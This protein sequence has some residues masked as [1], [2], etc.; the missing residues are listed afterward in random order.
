MSQKDNLDNPE[1]YSIKL[2]D[3]IIKREVTWKVLRIKFHQNSIWKD[4]ITTLITEGY[5]TRRALKKKIKR[6]TPFH[7]RKMLAESL[8][9]SSI[10]YSIVL[11]KNA[12][13]YLTNVF[14]DYKTQLL[15]MS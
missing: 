6:L 10:N 3:S 13:A 9:L 14:K 8:I 12:P 15:T 1:L 7:V 11:Y 2:A 4:Q 5:S